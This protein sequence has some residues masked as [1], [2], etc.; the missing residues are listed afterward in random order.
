MTDHFDLELRERLARMAAAVPAEPPGLV[1]R[2]TTPSVRAGTTTRRLALGGMVPILAVAVAGTLLAALAKV[3]P[4]APGATARSVPVVATTTG[5]PF[6]LAIR[7][8]KARYAPGEAIAIEATLTYRGPEPSLQ[9][10]HA[11]GA[12]GGPVGFG[13]DEPVLGELRLSPSWSESCE[14]STLQPGQPLTVP[15]EKS[16]AWSGNDPRSS[17]YQAVVLEPALR[18]SAGTW[19]PYAIAE[20]SIGECSAYQI[21]MRVGIEIEVETGTGVAP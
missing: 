20:F 1:G 14:R 2:V 16:A 11:Q 3:G 18:L 8:S 19:H 17:E 10:A 4:F 7:S 6:E 12:A 21:E 9:I 5:G 15:F 13:I